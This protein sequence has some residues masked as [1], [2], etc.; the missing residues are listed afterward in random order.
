MPENISDYIPQH[1]DNF[2]GDVWGVVSMYQG[3]SKDMRALEFQPVNQL[4]VVNIVNGKVR[5]LAPDKWE[6]FVCAGGE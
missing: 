1:A 6:T 2:L 4:S 5:A 3:L